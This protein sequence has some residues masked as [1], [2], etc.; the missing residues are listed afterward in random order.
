MI[1]NCIQ[2]IDSNIHKY[3]TWALP[4]IFYSKK[5]LAKILVENLP[6]KIIRLMTQLRFFF[7]FY[8][9]MVSIILI[10]F[11]CT[12]SSVNILFNT[13]PSISQEQNDV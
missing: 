13:I 7:I 9:V 3:C 10:Y 11:I 5:E 6:E 1:S 12:T 4:T 2:Q 8:E